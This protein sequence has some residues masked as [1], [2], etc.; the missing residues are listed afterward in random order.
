M[1][2]GKATAQ[3]VPIAQTAAQV[4]G[5]IPG[6]AM[7]KDYVKMVGRGPLLGLWLVNT[8][9]RRAAFARA[10][11]RILLGGAIHHKGSV[12]NESGILR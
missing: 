10:P 1:L 3:Q 11:E 12:R 6:T 7:T 5:P 9:N 8:R 2:A 4:P